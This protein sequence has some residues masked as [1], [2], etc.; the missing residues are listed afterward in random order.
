M[1]NTRR[2]H[3]GTERYGSVRDLSSALQRQSAAGT[4]NIERDAAVGTDDGNVVVEELHGVGGER[5]GCALARDDISIAPV[6]LIELLL[7]SD[8][9]GRLGLVSRRG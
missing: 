7:G 6:R 1:K 2:K 9:R 3:L 8:G 4:V 5:G